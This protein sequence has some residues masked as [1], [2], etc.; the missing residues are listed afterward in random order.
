VDVSLEE[1]PTTGYRWSVVEMPPEVQL[2]GAEFQDA[3]GPMTMGGRGT[4][5]FHFRVEQPGVHHVILHQARQWAPDAPV[6]IM[7]VELDI[8]D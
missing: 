4:R 2:L 3:P 7:T 5:V 8:S 1:S 6:E